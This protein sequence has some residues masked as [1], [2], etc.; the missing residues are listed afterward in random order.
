[1]G[2]M[3]PKNLIILKKGPGEIGVMRSRCRS[4]PAG[5]GHC[6]YACSTGYVFVG[7]SPRRW[8]EMP[9]RLGKA[10]AY[11]GRLIT[12]LPE[13]RTYVA[14]S[15]NEAGRFIREYIL[16][17]RMPIN[18]ELHVTIDDIVRKSHGTDR[19]FSI[20]G[21]SDIFLVSGT[22]P[23]SF[24]E[25]VPE[26]EDT[27]KEV[28]KRAEAAITEFMRNEADPYTKTVEATGR[29][30]VRPDFVKD[31]KR[32][33]P[34]GGTCPMDAKRK[35]GEE[36]CLR[37]PHNMEGLVEDEP[38]PSEDVLAGLYGYNGRNYIPCGFKQ[39]TKVPRYEIV[40]PLSAASEC[41][42]TYQVTAPETIFDKDR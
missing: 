3:I 5:N 33:L 30:P 32:P 20:E 1:M 29:C 7:R 24:L 34:F 42:R 36:S 22:N 27:L 8:D 2:L 11:T 12:V 21:C 26:G 9:C 19:C 40:L 16:G 15:Q 14:L 31:M 10:G 38:T 13:K 39:K 23:L 28:E 6:E 17:L 41:A 37:C 4:C 18:P 35:A 25:R